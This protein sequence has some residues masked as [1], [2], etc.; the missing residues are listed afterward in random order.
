[1][2]IKKPSPYNPRIRRPLSS[3]ETAILEILLERWPDVFDLDEP[4][5]LALGI[6]DHIIAAEPSLCGPELEAFLQWY[7]SRGPYVLAMAR[8]GKRAGLD[9]KAAGEVSAQHQSGARVAVAKFNLRGRWLRVDWPDV[10]VKG[11]A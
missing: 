3:D 2:A 5:P 9:G 11:G 7:T 6:H 4:V 1:M 10:A 8:G